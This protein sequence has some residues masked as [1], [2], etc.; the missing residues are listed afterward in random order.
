MCT[1]GRQR[2]RY[3]RIACTCPPLSRYSPSKKTFAN[4]QRRRPEWKIEKIQFLLPPPPDYDDCTSR[5]LPGVQ[6]G[7][8]EIT[9]P[10]LFAATIEIWNDFSISIT[11][12]AK[13]IT[14]K[15]VVASSYIYI[16]FSNL[17]RR[18]R[19]VRGI[20]TKTMFVN[21]KL[22]LYLLFTR[23]GDEMYLP[24][25]DYSMIWSSH[26]IGMLYGQFEKRMQLPSF[27]S[28]LSFDWCSGW[29]YTYPY[30][31][32]DERFAHSVCYC[33]GH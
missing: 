14:T 8:H 7:T 17:I 23:E 27:L 26:E 21:Y 18:S 15:N 3:L 19:W 2:E 4:Y 20:S 6:T 13:M 28:T 16:F 24:I 22:V 5:V 33:G 25:E 10:F 30:S 9:A 1:L 29:N 32:S 31:D 11:Y 12:P